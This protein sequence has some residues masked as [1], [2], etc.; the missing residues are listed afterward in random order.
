M[1]Y[2]RLGRSGLLVSAVGLGTNNFGGRT[3]EP[4]SRRV[5]DQAIESGINF[6]D[7]ANLYSNTISEQIIGNWMNG[8][9]DKVL[10]ATKF[11]WPVRP[12]PYGRG[13]SR[14]HIMAEVESSLRR[15]KTDHIDLYQQHLPDPGT[16]I[17]ETLRTLDDLVTQG[18]VRY[19]GASNFRGWQVAEAARAAEGMGTASFVSQQPY[20]NVLK[21]QVEKEVVPACAAYGIGLI[22]YRPLENGLLTGKYKRGERAPVGTRLAGSST[23]AQESAFSDHNFDRL[24][25]LE[26][27]AAERSIGLGE[28]AIAWLLANPL[29]GSVICG[30]TKPE[31]I[32]GNAKGADRKLVPTDIEAINAIAPVGP[33]DYEPLGPR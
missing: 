15:L 6:I 22:P 3:D 30:A 7:T 25:K 33:G 10:I 31:Q 21:R 8:K 5:L 27:F 20:Y 24:E 29:V 32:V 11:S 18:K 28:L 19:V 2:R 26:S 13:A 23:V 1:E 9:R 12:G 16:P 17:E 4:Q 14:L